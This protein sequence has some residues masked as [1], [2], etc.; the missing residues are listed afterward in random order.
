MWDS[1]LYTPPGVI[2]PQEHMQIEGRLDKWAE[3][4]AV[5]ISAAPFFLSAGSVIIAK[6]LYRH[7]P[8]HSRIFRTRYVPF[9]SHRP[10]ERFPLYLFGQP[11]RCRQTIVSH[12]CIFRL[13]AFL[14]RDK[15]RRVSRGDPKGS[16]T[17]KAQETITNFGVW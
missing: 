9:G 3:E 14:H 8:I 1:A 5:S 15:F 13:S 10:H 6:K 4:L 12:Q 2:S 11:R 7:L 17:F 16:H